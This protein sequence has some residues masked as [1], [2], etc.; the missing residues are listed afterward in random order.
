MG[1]LCPLV[2]ICSFF[3]PSK[4]LGKAIRNLTRST[5]LCRTRSEP[6]TTSVRRRQLFLIWPL[7]LLTDSV[8]R[9]LIVPLVTRMRRGTKESED[10]QE[11]E[12]MAE[13][14]DSDHN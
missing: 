9:L 10:D 1:V 14:G 5:C 3:K 2:N 7:L 13:E 11:D 6:L 12:T 8:R 4:F